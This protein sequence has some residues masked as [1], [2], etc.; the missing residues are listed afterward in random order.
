MMG[1]DLVGREDVSPGLDKYAERLLQ[2]PDE[3]KFFF[4]A[5][6]TTWFGSVDENL[7]IITITS[8]FK[9]KFVRTQILEYFSSILD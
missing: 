7:V 4:H 1:F 5:G 9:F 8:K 6:E 2:L 3:I